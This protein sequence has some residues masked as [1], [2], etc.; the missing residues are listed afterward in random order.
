MAEREVEPFTLTRAAWEELKGASSR[1]EE[2]REERRYMQHRI[3]SWAEYDAR[4][5]E[6]RD[7]EKQLQDLLEEQ[8]K[9]YEQ[10]IK[11]TQPAVGGPFAVA[12]PA[13]QSFC[14]KPSLI[15]YISSTTQLP[16]LL[17]FVASSDTHQSQ[18]LHFHAWVMGHH[19]A[20]VQPTCVCRMQ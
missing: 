19:S 17:V 18:P 7:R 1:Y 8:G 6:V 15:D 5:Q 20:S 14:N 11:L 12:A 9:L 10:F 3:T 2:A 13:Q 16:R 4:L